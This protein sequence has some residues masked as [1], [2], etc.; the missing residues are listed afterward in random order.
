MCNYCIQYTV[1]KGLAKWHDS[2][3][4]TVL[5]VS[6]CIHSSINN[7]TEKIRY[8]SFCKYV[9]FLL[10]SENLSYSSKTF[11]FSSQPKKSYKALIT[12]GVS[13][14]LSKKKL[15]DFDKLYWNLHYDFSLVSNLNLR[16]NFKGLPGMHPKEKWNDSKK[17]L[18]E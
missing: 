13:Q 7:S 14:M 8:W 12:C 4:L 18:Q 17:T 3:F 1:R 11:F 10:V 9:A 6:S 5:I 16:F 15:C 2:R